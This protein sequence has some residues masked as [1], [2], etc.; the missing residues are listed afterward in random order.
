MK[1]KPY[2]DHIRKNKTDSLI[3]LKCYLKGLQV[4]GFS[5]FKEDFFF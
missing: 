2:E 5:I 1:P 4:D 3:Y